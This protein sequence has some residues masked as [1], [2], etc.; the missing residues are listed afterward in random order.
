MQLNWLLL[1]ENH[2]NKS[3]CFNVSKQSFSFG[4]FQAKNQE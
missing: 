4:Y 2:G 3:F 1:V